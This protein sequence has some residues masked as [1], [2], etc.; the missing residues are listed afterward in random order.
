M[1]TNDLA[2]SSV[3]GPVRSVRTE[4]LT[5]DLTLEQ[6]TAPKYFGIVRFRPDGRIGETESHNRDGSVSRS[7]YIYDTAGRIQQEVQFG[8][9]GVPSGKTLYSYDEAGRLLRMASEDP[10]GTQRESEAYNY[11]QDGKT[12]KVVFLPKLEPNVGY[13]IDSTEQSYD[14][15]GAPIIATRYERPGQ[16]DEKLFYD[17]D[18]RLLM[19]VIFTRDGTGRLMSEEMHREGAIPSLGAVKELENAP[20]GTREA[21]AAALAKLF[22]TQRCT[23]YSYDGKGRLQERRM[24]MGE[25]ADHRTTYRYDDRDR[26]IEEST[27]H[28]SRRMRM[29]GAG[30]V[31]PTKETSKVQHMRFEYEYDAQ[32]NWTER[33]VWLRPEP[34]PNFERSNATRREIGYYS[35]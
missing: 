10:H 14:A 15:T 23:T 17:S 11:G 9:N 6:W 32:G 28:S 2:Q 29:D 4:H 12:T 13:G 5:W 33:V 22:G 24:R 25:L 8:V 1:P 20:E 19:R 34:N 21:M 3:H 35:S 7:S 30:N 31:L 26:L 27:E 16:P 18:H